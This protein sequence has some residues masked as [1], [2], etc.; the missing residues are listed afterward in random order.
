[1][2]GTPAVSVLMT[3]YNRA[4]YIGPAIESVLA[5]W[6]EEWELVIVDDG[7]TDGTV[8]VARDYARRDS[9]IRFHQNERNLGDY[10]NR[11][12]AAELARA[13]LFRY[14]DSDD[15]LYPH[16]LTIS[17][18]LL[19]AEPRAALALSPPKDWPG[20]PCPMLLTPRMMYQREF[21]SMER[22]FFMGPACGLFR[23]DAFFALGAFDDWGVASD[24][25]F[26]LKACARVN[27][28]AIPPG[29]FWYRSHPGQSLQG[30]GAAMKYTVVQGQRLRALDAPE[31]PLLPG[32]REEARRGVVLNLVRELE[33]DLKGRRLDLARAR[34]RHAGIGLADIARHLRRPHRELLIGTPL[35][36]NGEYLVPDWDAYRGTAPAPDA[37]G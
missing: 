14:C 27:V 29:L 24:N 2:Q 32:E 9:R 28:L 21:L 3:S 34:L 10:P 35:D 4:S 8:D 19:Q 25:A 23:R 16:C 26:W 20:G 7:S 31:C 13:P 18:P 5:Q 37:R 11:N 15:L 12:R 33:R 1:M 30:A 17:V 22:P 6:F 36:A